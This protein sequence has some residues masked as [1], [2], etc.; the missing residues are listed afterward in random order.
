MR[1]VWIGIA[2]SFAAVAASADELCDCKADCAGRADPTAGM[3]YED[4]KHRLWYEVRFWT[5]KCRG[6]I[7]LACWSGPSWYDVMAEVLA[8]G[9]AEDRP[10][11]CRRLYALGV[12]MG[13][14]WAR[15]NDIRVIHTEDL[16]A[17]QGDLL[18]TDDP[19]R[20]IGAV[21]ALV[22]ARLE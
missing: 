20:A 5:G 12:R 16:D 8:Q 1:G 22:D 3:T 6:E 4:D 17:W 18:H 2:M 15:D 13:H 19:V 10:E 21:E 9:A 11:M 7:W 14:E